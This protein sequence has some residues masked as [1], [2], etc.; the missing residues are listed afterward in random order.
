MQLQGVRSLRREPVG[1]LTGLLFD[2]DFHGDVFFWDVFYGSFEK[3]NIGIH[4]IQN[5]PSGMGRQFL[6]D[7]SD[8]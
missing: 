6:T 7:F 3:K 4:D 1:L 2:W 5:D 8:G